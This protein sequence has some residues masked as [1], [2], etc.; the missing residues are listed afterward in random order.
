MIDQS[1]EVLSNRTVA[2]GVFLLAFK[3]REIA[4]T[5]APGQFVMIQVADG[6]APLLRRPFSVCGVE[7]EDTVLVLYKKVG[8]GTALLS[9]IE[10][11]RLLNVLGP[12]GKGFRLPDPQAFS[13]FVSG[14]IGAAPL[15]FLARSLAGHRLV[16]FAGYRTSAEIP[17]ESLFGI[18]RD[19]FMVT[20]DDGSAG[21]HCLVTE[22]L[23]NRMKGFPEKW[24]IFSCGPTPMLKYV[25]SLAKRNGVSAQLSIE[26]AMACGVGACQG[27]TVSAPAGGGGYRRVCVDGP[28]FYSGDIDWSRL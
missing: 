12:L 26:T 15:T 6:P 21:S 25:A 2:E 3:C 11:G 28:V 7:G 9:G 19:N 17:P 10:P 24:E 20:T 5:A 13:V 18:A 14:G 4:S 8:F 27:C 23:E 16:W 22:L 1:V